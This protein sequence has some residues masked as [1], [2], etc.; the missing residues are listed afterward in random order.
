MPLFGD[1]KC[2]MS[3][4][5]NAIAIPAWLWLEDVHHSCRIGRGRCSRSE[6]ER[7]VLAGFVLLKDESIP[8]FRD[9]QHQE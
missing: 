9:H 1:S 4:H 7:C 6:E 3:K 8:G 5:S 2:A